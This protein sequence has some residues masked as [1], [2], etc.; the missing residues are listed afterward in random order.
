[1]KEVGSEKKRK[2]K[3]KN[4]EVLLKLKRRKRNRGRANIFLL[5]FCLFEKQDCVQ[6]GK[7]TTKK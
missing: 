3:K 6:K 4:S 2:G 7:E 5:M 1:M